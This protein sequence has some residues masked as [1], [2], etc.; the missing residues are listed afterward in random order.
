M[1]GQTPSQTVGPFFAYGLVPEAYG[2]PGVAGGR[3]AGDGVPGTRIRLTGRVFD[4]AG[5]PVPDAL[6]EVWQADA[7]GNYPTAEAQRAGAFRGFGRVATDADGGF[8]FETV[9][10]GRVPGRGNALQ[11]PHLT[12]VIFAR[13]LLH[14]LI[15]I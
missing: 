9:K 5:A 13:G 15:R 6:V 1:A 11:A 8:A 3:I 7:D 12:L 4:G 10:P 14:H 2:W